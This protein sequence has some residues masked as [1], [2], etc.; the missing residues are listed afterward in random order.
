MNALDNKPKH[1]TEDKRWKMVDSTMRKYGH[2]PEAMIETLHRV[3]ELFGF[4]DD[5]ALHYV[6]NTLRLPKSKVFGV[7][8]FYHHFQLKPQGKHTCVVCMGTACYIKGAGDLLK[9]LEEDKN[10]LPGET[11]EDKQVS[12]FASRCV[13]TC[14]MAPAVVIDQKIIGNVTE[15]SI[16]NEFE[17]L[18]EE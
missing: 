12:L 2:R 16:V 7:A 13:G 11:T 8:S 1:P 10:I 15:D 4:L 9:K 18:E 17:K 3:Q 5:D 6:A 14:S